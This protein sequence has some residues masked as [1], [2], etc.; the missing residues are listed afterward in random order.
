MVYTE[1][2]V[3]KS[4]SVISPRCFFALLQL[5]LQVS[6]IPLVDRCFL[7]QQSLLRGKSWSRYGKLRQIS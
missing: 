1:A 4:S 6:Q 7:M 3:E 2:P 5:D